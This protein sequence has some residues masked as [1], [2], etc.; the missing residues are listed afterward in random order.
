VVVMHPNVTSEEVQQPLGLKMIEFLCQH[1]VLQI[2]VVG[3]N[4][5]LVFCT[6]QEVLPLLQSAHDCQHLIVMDVIL[7]LYPIQ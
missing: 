3:P 5:K 7:S 2:L 4:L 6:F 1:E